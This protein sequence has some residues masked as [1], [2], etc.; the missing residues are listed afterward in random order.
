M[1]KAIHKAEDREQFK[2]AMKKIGIDLPQ[3]RHRA[4]VS[5][6]K[7]SRWSKKS[8]GLPTA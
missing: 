4:H 2:Q 8:N 1:I 7:R 6:R 5:G 3:Q